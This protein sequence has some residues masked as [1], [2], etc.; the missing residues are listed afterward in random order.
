V[1]LALIVALCADSHA[2]QV[3]FLADVR[4]QREASEM[5]RIPAGPFAMGLP[6]HE[7][8]NAIA[9]C[10][11]EFGPELSTQFCQPNGQPLLHNARTGPTS[12]QVSLL[13]YDLDRFEV[14][15]RHYRSCVAAGRC[16]LRPLVSGD[17]RFIK[18]DW[19]VVNVTW[20]DARD[21]C[22]Y[23]G[24]RLPTEAEWEKAA[25]GTDGRR[26]PWGDR[27]R[28]DSANRGAVQP[29]LERAPILYSFPFSMDRTDG[30]SVLAPPGS[31]PWGKSPWGVY[32]M[33]GNVAEWVADW[34]APTYP[35]GPVLA[36]TGPLQGVLRSFRGGSYLEPKF[37]SR[38]Y[39]RMS[40]PPSERHIALGFRCARDAVP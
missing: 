30:A 29:E 4:A 21:Y 38:A 2:T 8:G 34:Y 12:L 7:L 19:P 23:R 17:I 28:T 31:Y 11:E 20:Y 24:K 22:A 25:R 16:D 32:D 40:A 13:A 35:S 26:W 15:T 10:A 9:A 37:L 3:L 36:P 1:S 33:S 18:D 39:V 6:D 14:T 27:D 5:V